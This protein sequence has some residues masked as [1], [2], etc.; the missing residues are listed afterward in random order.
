MQTNSNCEQQSS[1]SDQENPGRKDDAAAYKAAFYQA[2]DEFNEFGLAAG[3]ARYKI[4]DSL[5]EQLYL[6]KVS[7][8][9]LHFLVSAFDTMLQC[10]QV[11]QSGCAQK[12]THG[13][14]SA[15]MIEFGR[16]WNSISTSSE[17]MCQATVKQITVTTL[18]VLLC[19]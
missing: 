4:E 17:W 16:S 18:N 9:R 2:V 10:W 3:N 11:I 5:A 19:F 7:W 12:L 13:S 8:M 15:S 6:F 14:R 1:L